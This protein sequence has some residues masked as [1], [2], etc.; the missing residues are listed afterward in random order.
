MTF[1]VSLSL[2]GVWCCDLFAHRCGW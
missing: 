2:C 1:Y